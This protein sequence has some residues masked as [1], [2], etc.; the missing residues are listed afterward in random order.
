MHRPHGS[1]TLAPSDSSSSLSRLAQSPEDTGFA[2]LASIHGLD[3]YD[4][5]AE[6]LQVVEAVAIDLTVDGIHPQGVTA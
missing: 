1:K 2:F 6:G 4:G 3:I 5:A